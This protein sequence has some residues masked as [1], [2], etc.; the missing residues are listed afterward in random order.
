MPRLEILTVNNFKVILNY[1]PS[2]STTMVQ[3]FINNGFIDETK[4]N[5]GISHLLEHVLT[6][7]WVK[8]GSK[9]CYEYWRKKGVSLNASTDQTA[10]QYYVHG[11]KKFSKEMVD[12][13]TYLSVSPDITNARMEKEKKAVKNELMIHDSN[14]LIHVYNLLNKLLFRHEGL[15]HQDN[16]K[17]QIKNL[18]KI[19]IHH[20]KDWIKRFYGSNNMLFV[21]SGN[22]RKSEIMPI[23]KK[24]L[25][26]NTPV[27][28]APHYFDVFIPG[29]EVAYHK[30]TLIDNTNLIF[31]FHAPLYPNNAEIFY[32][33]FFE[34]FL[35]SGVTS[36]LMHELREKRQLIYTIDLFKIIKIFHWI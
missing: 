22:F 11:L 32:T 6:D 35:G 16:M 5:A 27:V 30:N 31:A 15:V 19:N 24:N 29:I 25:K 8:C 36:M 12:Y 28:S 17:L 33:D 9:G 14:P 23:L 20:L 2:T 4:E 10:V 21:I 3:S 1:N 7:A 18:K 34:K 26:K 13:I